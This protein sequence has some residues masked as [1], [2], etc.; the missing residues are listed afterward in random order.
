ML[1][2]SAAG[3]IESLSRLLR[4]FWMSMHDLG[5]D[6]WCLANTDGGRVQ[7]LGQFDLLFSGAPLRTTAVLDCGVQ[8]AVRVLICHRLL[9]LHD[10]RAWYGSPQFLLASLYQK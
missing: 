6:V 7:S 10:I 8:L 3:Q 4:L 9:V 1:A 5:G 2:I